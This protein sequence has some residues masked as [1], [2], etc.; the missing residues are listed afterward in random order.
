MPKRL[1]FGSEKN[2]VGRRLKDLREKSGMTQRELSEKFQLAGYDMDRNVITRME[3][4]QRYITD[5]E[6]QAIC[7]VFHVSYNFLFG[8]EE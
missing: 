2:I 3:T 4:N 7:E 6:I 1:K 8:I 5:I